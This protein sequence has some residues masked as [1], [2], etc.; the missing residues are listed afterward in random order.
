MRSFADLLGS[1]RGKFE[2]ISTSSEVASKIRFVLL[3]KFFYINQYDGSLVLYLCNIYANYLPHIPKYCGRTWPSWSKVGDWR[4]RVI[5]N[6][7]GTKF[8]CCHISRPGI[9]EL[10]YC[11]G[12]ISSIADC[13]NK[14]RQINYLSP[15]TKSSS[16]RT[17]ISFWGFNWKKYIHFIKNILQSDAFYKLIINCRSIIDILSV[18]VLLGHRP[19]IYTV[20]VE[21]W[22]HDLQFTILHVMY[23][24]SKWRKENE[25][26]VKQ[27][28]VCTCAYSSVM[29]SPFPKSTLT[30]S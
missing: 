29:W 2:Q 16:I 17:G 28:H 12:K 25:K 21:I 19:I 20:K 4:L 11:R 8:H 1:S 18:T 27:K 14:Q 13:L 3:F 15:M 10:H 22:S 26:K 30:S 7:S 5:L 9:A 6:F 23:V 24:K